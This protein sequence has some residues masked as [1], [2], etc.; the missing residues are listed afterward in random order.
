L[1]PEAVE[2]AFSW[3]HHSHPVVPCVSSSPMAQYGLFQSLQDMQR[4]QDSHPHVSIGLSKIP[5][6]GFS[7][8]TASNANARQLG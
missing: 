2:S 3:K 5:Y 1:F 4:Y 8:Y 7:L 6:V